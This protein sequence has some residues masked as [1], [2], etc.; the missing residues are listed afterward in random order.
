MDANTIEPLSAA[1]SDVIAERDRQKDVEGWTA[2]HD[3]KYTGCELAAAAATY[4]VCVRPDQL[5]VC[6]VTAWPW[7]YHWWK[8]GAYRRNLVKAA[9]L[10]IAEIER[11]DRAADLKAMP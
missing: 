8:P 4:A 5:K 11:I 7:P 10:L 3:D 1:C 9:A 6:G 2:E